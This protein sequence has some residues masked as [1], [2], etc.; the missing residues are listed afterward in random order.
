MPKALSHHDKI[1]SPET[2]EYL[3]E[4]YGIGDLL[5]WNSHEPGAW[6]LNMIIE[7][8]NGEYF[9]KE[10]G[11]FTPR[12]LENVQQWVYVISNMRSASIPVPRPLL[13]NTC[14]P[15]YVAEKHLFLLFPLVSGEH[16]DGAQLN[17][18]QIEHL[19]FLLAR[20][21]RVLGTIQCAL[22]NVWAYEQPNSKRT[23]KFIST[24]EEFVSPTDPILEVARPHFTLIRQ[25]IKQEQADPI[26]DIFPKWLIHGDLTPSNFLWRGDKIVAIL[27]WDD[28][29]GLNLRVLEVAYLMD[30]FFWLHPFSH[31]DKIALFMHSY[32]TELPLTR[33]EI[34]S[35]VDLHYW[36]RI[37]D[38][39]AYSYYLK[40]RNP[41]AIEF[42]R[43]THNNL[44]WLAE[45]R[46]KLN[47]FLCFI[48]L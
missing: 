41:R 11:R 13:N 29:L 42:A 39:W 37:H 45:N 9:L 22:D 34:T 14:E 46:A 47:A 36:Y 31:W 18:T 19:G 2:L 7:T 4:S 44:Q 16:L 15:W 1:L 3:C 26:P 12:T 43:D 10:Y 20:L 48:P 5:E 21:H 30:W 32:Q 25:L 8:T 27:D 40:T 24:F 33:S 35:L 28:S 38:T 23:I 17:R 6:K